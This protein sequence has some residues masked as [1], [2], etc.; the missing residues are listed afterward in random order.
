MTMTRPQPTLF[1]AT[2][3]AHFHSLYLLAHHGER[4]RPKGALDLRSWKKAVDE[5][6]RG[7]P[8]KAPESPFGWRSSESRET[9]VRG[10][11]ALA[12]RNDFLRGPLLSHILAPPEAFD[13][14]R[15]YRYRRRS[16]PALHAHLAWAHFALLYFRYS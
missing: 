15:R 14:L 6:L 2:L 1:D 10:D 13:V 9:K 12:A 11:A 7:G 3:S 8:V 4:R 16:L 5:L